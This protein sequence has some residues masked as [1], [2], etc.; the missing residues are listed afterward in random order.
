MSWRAIMGVAPA[1][2]HDPQKSHNPQKSEQAAI[3]ADIA[4]IADGIS[5]TT[6]VASP[7]PDGA[8]D[9]WSDWG[10]VADTSRPHRLPSRN[11]R[12]GWHGSEPKSPA[13][14]PPLALLP[15]T[16]GYGGSR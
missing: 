3:S 1:P 2:K 11:R 16:G 9:Q 4:N 14:F 13:A 10:T 7:A 8:G 5:T 6:G 12:I 15:Q